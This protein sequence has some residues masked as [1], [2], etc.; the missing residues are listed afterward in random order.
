[1]RK[2]P[3]TRPP[4]QHPQEGLDRCPCGSKYWDGDNCHSCGSRFSPDSETLFI[5]PGVKSTG[6]RQVDDTLRGVIRALNGLPEPEAKA[7]IESMLRV[8]R[9]FM[10]R[11]Q[12]VGPDAALIE[13]REW[14]EAAPAVILLVLQYIDYFAGLI[15]ANEEGKTNA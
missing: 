2:P 3:T 5:A 6:D 1:M 8:T 9:E 14:S 12:Q 4:D 11:A 13:A 7:T 10:R 15:R